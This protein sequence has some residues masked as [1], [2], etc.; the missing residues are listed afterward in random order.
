[1]IKKLLASI[2]LLLLFVFSFNNV[3]AISD[4]LSVPNNKFGIHI[5]DEN[6]LDDASGLVNSSGGDYGYITIVIREDER[7]LE[8][9]QNVFNK[10]RRLH[11][12]PIV[13]I[14]S[15]TYDHSWQKLSVDE[16]PGWV[17]FLN[18]L[19]WVTENRYVIIGNEP[20][21]ASEWGG[22]INPEEYSLY[23]KI[24]S[25]KL[26]SASADFFIL[27]AGLDA[28]A[29]DNKQHLSEEKFLNRMHEFDSNIFDNID[30]WS[31]HSYP[32]PNFSG[33]ETATGK[34]TLHTYEWEISLLK[35]MGFDKKLP[36]F[37]TETGWAHDIDGINS[38]YLSSIEVS[39][40][41][42]SSFENNWKDPNIV[43]ITPF[44]LN[45]SE[46][47][48]NIFSW[49]KPDGS[50]YDFYDKIKM[51]GKIKGEPKRISSAQII[52][53]LL[54]PIFKREDKKFS[55]VY[56]KNTGQ[57]I[58]KGNQLTEVSISGKTFNIEPIILL[59]D[60]EPGEKTFALYGFTKI[61]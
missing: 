5:I 52:S 13:R 28:S 1:M 10:A 20:N 57:T 51:L 50:Y 44:I 31:S 61:R 15:K 23:L 40:R 7:N 59:K 41:M 53:V 14:A 2:L 49:K 37:I 4:P 19:N 30:G 34:G 60:V 18:E 32:N 17:S 25:S 55:L 46:P 12:I 35:E 39:K 24:I 22:T 56:L 3:S 42:I 36:V 43:A 48:F 58:W 29:P 45:Y 21:H 47:P 8:R 33:S 54:P 16:I 9:W 11:L 27:P 38:K 6:D 26:K